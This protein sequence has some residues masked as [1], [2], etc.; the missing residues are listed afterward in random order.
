MYIVFKEYDCVINH[1]AIYFNSLCYENTF[2]HKIQIESFIY[3][4]L[5]SILYNVIYKVH[6]FKNDGLNIINISNFRNIQKINYKSNNYLIINCIFTVKYAFDI[7]T[8]HHL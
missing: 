8:N 5:L 3:S 7:Y 2:Y 1:F 6:I 4:I